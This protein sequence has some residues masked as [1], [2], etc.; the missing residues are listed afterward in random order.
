M[1]CQEI[2]ASPTP[3]VSRP[4]VAQPEPP[5]S[6]GGAGSRPRSGLT[7]TQALTADARTLQP[8]LARDA[9]SAAF[10]TNH[11]NAPLL[12]RNADT[13]EWDA[14][15]GTASAV[16]ISDGGRTLTYVLREGLTWSDGTPL[17]SDDYRFTFERMVDPETDHPYR[18]TFDRVAS[19]EA[20]DPRTLVWS[21]REAF[22][23]AID[24]TVI[25]PIPR[26]VFDGAALASHPASRAPVV[27]SG[28]FLLEEWQPGVSATFVAN[29]RFYLGRPR[30]DRHVLRLVPDAATSWAMVKSGD[31]DLAA[32]QATDAAEATRTPGIGTIAHYP[33]TSSWT[34][35]GMNLRHPVLSDLRVRRAI[36]HAIDRK[37]LVQDVRLGHARL[38]E[39]PIARESWAAANLPGV[40]HDPGAARRLLDEAEWGS[41]FEGGT[42]TREGTLLSLTLHFPSGTRERERVATMVKEDLR[43][44][45]VAV[46]VVPESLPDLIDRVNVTH[47]YD[48]CLLGWTAPVE[49]HGTREIWAS[50]GAQNGSGLADPIVDDLYD[51]AVHVAGCGRGDR[52]A[53]YREIQERI[54]AAVPCVFLFEN[55]SIAAVSDR[56]RV[57][58]VSRLGWDYRP[59]E[60]SL[61][62]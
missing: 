45:G 58:P 21:F 41:Q 34:Y 10:I 59:W 48:L 44:I 60:W 56:V 37:A 2:G 32:I 55:E 47:E 14:T 54:A 33:A 22:C 52:A 12:R 17:T 40:P 50:G 6:A 36:A 20:P 51:R 35:V 28:P 57:N 24:F 29:D 15:D 18:T 39:S 43:A 7:V 4:V 62:A 1:A 25:N 31:V 49:P 8:L 5:P 3:T 19:V 38:V 16:V 61:R 53:L 27:G 11:Y 46:D 30:I 42:R 23:P 13:L 9:A 26:H